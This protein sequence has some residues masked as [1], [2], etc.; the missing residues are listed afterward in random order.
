MNWLLMITINK[1]EEARSG[2]V[3]GVAMKFT[4]RDFQ[5]K[6]AIRNFGLLEMYI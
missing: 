5:L 1:L 4:E 2:S 6:E 3:A